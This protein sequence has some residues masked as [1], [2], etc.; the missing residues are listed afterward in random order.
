MFTC[1]CHNSPQI[2]WARCLSKNTT[3]VGRGGE[4]RAVNGGKDTVRVCFKCSGPRR[5]GG[6]ALSR[7]GETGGSVVAGARRGNADVRG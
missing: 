2:A 6:F 3:I 7:W 5:G 4:K 1:G